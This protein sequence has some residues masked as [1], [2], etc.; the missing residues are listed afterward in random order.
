MTNPVTFY[1]STRTGRAM[2]V[3]AG[4]W[5][6]QYLDWTLAASVPRPVLPRRLCKAKAAYSLTQAKRFNNR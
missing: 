5:A 4:S 6:L 1:R 2:G 3:D